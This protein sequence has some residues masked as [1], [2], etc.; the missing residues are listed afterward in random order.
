ML[1]LRS[2]QDLAQVPG[3]V[4]LAIGVFDGVHLG[5]QEVIRAAQEHAVQHHGQAVVM[6]FDPHPLSVLRPELKPK[7]L[8]GER[9]RSRLLA[10]MGVAG[11]LLCPFTRE[12]A[13]TSAE[14]FVGSLVAACHPLGCIS[15]GYTWSFGKNR[16]GNIHSLMDLG[17]RHDFAVYGVPPI[18]L[19]GEVVS[20]TLIRDAVTSGN[21]TRAASL[22]GRPYSLLGTVVSGRQ[23]ARQ[24]GFPT[25]N[26]QPEAEVLPPYGVYAVQ[27]NLGGEWFP[28][29]A[30]LGLRP[31]VD[32]GAAAPSL[33]VHLFDWS[34]DLYGQE[35]EVRLGTFLRPE[36]KF[37]GVD[38]LLS[39]IQV[40]VQQARSLLPG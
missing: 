24:L 27:A 30:N 28:G 1:Q 29:I 15:V 5:H 6:S 2:I 36:K 25:A 17:Q 8:C 26:V 18:R 7:R 10:S 19:E 39:Q 21:L 32:E 22:L 33:E 37:T 4:S 34:G 3:P 12:V 35:L 13:D 9:Q 20:S 40:D 31:T 16:S 23:L 11:T 38:A 14:E